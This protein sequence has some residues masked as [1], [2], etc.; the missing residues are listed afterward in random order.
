[1]L[2]MALLVGAK[3]VNK[4]SSLVGIWF[5]Y[6]VIH[7]LDRWLKLRRPSTAEN[8]LDISTQQSRTQ[9]CMDISTCRSGEMK[10]DA[11]GRWWCHGVLSPF[12]NYLYHAPAVAQ[13]HTRIHALYAACVYV[14]QQ[15]PGSRAQLMCLFQPFSLPPP[16]VAHPSHALMVGNLASGTSWLPTSTL[17]GSWAEGSF[18]QSSLASSITASTCLTSAQIKWLTVS[19]SLVSR[20]DFNLFTKSELTG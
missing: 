13:Q 1:M 16:G 4:Y 17:A 19:S 5:K 10:T 11:V 12:L 20:A 9:N 15:G 7:H 2:I 8:T 14:Y 3:N 6:F 18:I